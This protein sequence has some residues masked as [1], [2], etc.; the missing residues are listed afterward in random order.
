M[1]YTNA[2]TRQYWA[3]FANWILLFMGGCKHVRARPCLHAARA[4]RVYSDVNWP[5]SAPKCS[6]ICTIFGY[7]TNTCAAHNYE[8][9]WL[10]DLWYECVRISQKLGGTLIRIRGFWFALLIVER[11]IVNVGTGIAKS[12]KI[13]ISQHRLGAHITANGNIVQQCAHNDSEIKQMCIIM[14]L[15]KAVFVCVC[16][17]VS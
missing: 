6:Y 14:C 10:R 11:C 9:M 7:T 8:I 12:I 13:R 16:T 17:Q 2:L 1:S 4:K 3:E 5:L 15:W